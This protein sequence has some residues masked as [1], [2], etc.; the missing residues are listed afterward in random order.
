MI[1]LLVYHAMHA[2]VF[3]SMDI[4]T[5][6]SD[7][8]NS[9]NLFEGGEFLY[10]LMT[11]D[12]A[13]SGG[14]LR[15]VKED[16]G[17]DLTLSEGE[18]TELEMELG[19]IT[20]GDKGEMD[21]FYTVFMDDPGK[22]PGGK[23]RFAGGVLLPPSFHSKEGKERM[24][25]KLLRVNEDILRAKRGLSGDGGGSSGDVDVEDNHSRNVE[26]RVG[27]LPK[28]DAAVAQHPFTDG[29]FSALLQSYKVSLMIM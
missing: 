24:K 6:T 5:S 17:L 23:C 20:D 21:L 9:N 8:A 19:I 18:L 28:V 14:T 12:Y 11:K 29:A 26:Y 4:L 7:H 27:N 25:S 15:T 10:K 3:Y 16:L 22:V 13:A 1:T 2:G